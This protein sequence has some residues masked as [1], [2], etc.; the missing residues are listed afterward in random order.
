MELFSSVVC[1]Q[2]GMDSLRKGSPGIE[3]PLSFF[4]PR[5]LPSVIT[6]TCSGLYPDT[7]KVSDYHSTANHCF[8]LSDINCRRCSRKS[9]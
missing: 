3:P 2:P 7:L 9:S 6:N 4:P 1:G 5:I 8:I